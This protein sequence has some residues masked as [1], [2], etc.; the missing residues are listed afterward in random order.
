MTTANTSST[1]LVN[2]AENAE[3]R[4][5]QI[6]SESAVSSSFISDCESCIAKAEASRL[7]KTVI[8]DAGAM[9]GFFSMDTEEEC[10]S[11][12]SLLAALLDK[13]D[14]DE[15]AESET[16]LAMK[17]ADSISSSS[18]DAHRRVSILCALYNLRSDYGEKCQLLA[19]IVSLCDKS[20]PELL[21]DEETLAPIVDADNLVQMLDG[22]GVSVEEKRNL[23]KTVGNSM[24]GNKRQIYLLLLLETYNDSIDTLAKDT[25]VMTIAKDAVVGAISD[26]I[27]LFNKQRGMLSWPGVVAL[28]RD[29]GMYNN[30]LLFLFYLTFTFTHNAFLLRIIF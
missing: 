11:A 29:N 1:T 7:I 27:T 16:E 5:V 2:V 6:L 21:S 13:V 8:Q 12:F 15:S 24:T 14:A 22:W 19:R 4:L 18:G 23:L 9:R 30:Q 25:E 26:P 10:V 20:C 3:I 28:K 17:L